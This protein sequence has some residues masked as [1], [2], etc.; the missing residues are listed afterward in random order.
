MKILFPIG[1]FYPAQLGGPSNTI[2]WIAKALKKCGAHPIVVSTDHG[3]SGLL[4]NE[5][6]ELDCG[7]VI[8]ISVRN[9][10]LNPMHIYN[11]LHSS[12]KADIIHLTSLF[13]PPSF[14]TG[15]FS[16]ITNQ[17]VIWSP[18]GELSPIALQFSTVKKKLFLKIISQIKNKVVFHATSEQEVKDIQS[19]FGTVK[20]IRIPNYMELPVKKRRNNKGSPFFLYVGRIH[21]IKALDNLLQSLAESKLFRQSGY[22][23]LVGGDA[24]NEYG[25]YLQQLV[26]ELNLE[27]QVLFLGTVKGELKEQLFA[28]ADFFFLPSHS[29][30]FGNVVIESLAQ[31]T[32]V[33]AGLGTPWQIL[34]EENAGYW[35]SNEPERLAIAI[36]EILALKHSDYIAMRKNAYRLA[37]E[38]FD[39]YKNINVWLDAYKSIL[40]GS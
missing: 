12:R 10:L 8:Y 7:N 34:Q 23:L 37:S 25:S 19:I 40:N 15:L 33:I 20:I 24:N 21:P 4:T 14:I 29:E 39:I 2:Y 16:S 9:H 27:G 31:G 13:Y 6:K 28:D 17:K 26:I 1:S 32:P 11:C 35:V 3:T 5:W 22:R 38:R 30:N 36:D 18:R